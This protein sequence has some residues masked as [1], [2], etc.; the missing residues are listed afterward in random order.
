MYILKSSKV[1]LENMCSGN[2]K[3]TR[4]NNFKSRY[5]PCKI[6]AEEPHFYK[7]ATLLKKEHLHGY[8]SRTLPRFSE[9]P[10]SRRALN[11][12]FRNLLTC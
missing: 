6:T 4:T 8:F 1:V 12:C 2:L 3:K 11:G 7:P 9:H 5:N 10:F